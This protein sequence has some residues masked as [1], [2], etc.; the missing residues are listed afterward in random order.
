[1]SRLS[2]VPRRIVIIG[3][4]STGKSTLTQQ[5]A[6]YF[7]ATGVPEFAR[8]YLEHI[9]RAYEPEDLTAIAYGQLELEEQAMARGGEWI[10]CDTD[11]YVVKVW[12]ESRYGTCDE[13][14]LR[15]IAERRYDFYLLTDIDMPWEDDPLREHPAPEMRRYFFN[16]YKDIVAHSGVPF[17]IVKGNEVRR[18]ETAIKALEALQ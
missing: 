14:I 12:S 16:I 11:L 6:A 8:T 3:P 2:A 15:V 9:G 4:E 5:L 17:A 18:L 10:F 1:M 7:G 13:A